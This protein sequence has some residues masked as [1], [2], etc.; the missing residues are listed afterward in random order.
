[1]TPEA[2]KDLLNISKNGWWSVGRGKVIY[3]FLRY[4][5]Y[6]NKISKNINILDVGAGFNPYANIYKKFGQFDLLE[7]ENSCVSYLKKNKNYRKLFTNKV[8]KNFLNK[9]K[10]KYD[11]VLSLD[12]IEHIKDDSRFLL[13]L[14]KIIKN[15]GILIAT[16]PAFNF[17][18]SS[19]DEKYGHYR[20]YTKNEFVN[21]FEKA[22]FKLKFISYYNFFLFPLALIKI[23]LLKLTKE[24]DS[25]DIDPSSFT[26]TI[27]KLIFSFESFLLPN[28]KFPFGVSIIAVA[29]K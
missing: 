26:N 28:L 18:W 14:N 2:Y 4:L 20:R 24:T 12:V 9:N 17:L 21:L 15:N 3:K 1:M 19:H 25:K 23:L 27:F 7:Y 5:S 16:V 29:S 6:Q 13:N 8:D 10:N 11:L 22:G